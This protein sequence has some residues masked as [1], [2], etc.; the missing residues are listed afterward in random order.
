MRSIEVRVPLD[1][2]VMPTERI[3]QAVLKPYK[4]YKIVGLTS[5]VMFMKNRSKLLIGALIPLLSMII[6]VFC[7]ASIVAGT[8]RDHVYAYTNYVAGRK[9]IMILKSNAQLSQRLILEAILKNSPDQIKN[10]R[11]KVK[12]TRDDDEHMLIAYTSGD[13]P[14]KTEKDLY[15]Q[16]DILRQNLYSVQDRVLGLVD[17]DEK[18]REAA[19]TYFGELCSV[20]DEYSKGLQDL[21]DFL[22]EYANM[23]HART[24]INSEGMFTILIEITSA[25][26][27]ITVILMI[28]SRK[29]YG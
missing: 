20:T 15:S 3:L 8:N 29:W 12:Q 25:V 18:T 5:E 26:T 13:H 7:G 16:A 17:D 14:T 23:W 4:K 9:N 22:E 28:R 10:T 21:A 6:L 19:E 27:L 2:D 11:P 24:A 1:L